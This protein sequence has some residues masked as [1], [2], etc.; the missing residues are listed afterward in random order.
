MVRQRFKR[1]GWCGWLWLSLHGFAL[2]APCGKLQPANG[3]ALLQFTVTSKATGCTYRYQV[4][5]T[6]VFGVPGAELWRYSKCLQK[7][8]QVTVPSGF[9]VQEYLQ[10]LCGIE[11]WY[12]NLGSLA[13]SEPA[14]LASP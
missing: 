12:S 5:Y 2:G 3:G 10:Q 14:P 11:W 9:T 4:I 13:T 8:Q 7:P 1:F 6:E